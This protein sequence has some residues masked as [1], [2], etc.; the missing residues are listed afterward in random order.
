MN[1]VLISRE[2]LKRNEPHYD[3]EG[4][5]IFYESEIDNAPTVKNEYMRG[6]EAAMREYKRQPGKWRLTLT[7]DVICSVCKLPRRDTRIDHI[8]FCNH[9][10]ADMRGNNEK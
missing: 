6:Y 1:N 7:G 8:Q 3:E 2:A 5:R 10:G 9:C 4:F